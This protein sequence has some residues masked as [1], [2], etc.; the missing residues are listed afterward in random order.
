MQVRRCCDGFGSLVRVQ[1]Y[2][3]MA[4]V[5]LYDG[6][7]HKR[8]RTKMFFLAPACLFQLLEADC[9]TLVDG[10]GG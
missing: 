7:G 3:E 2:R 5:K 1:T 6:L 10:V 4:L 8:G 9:C